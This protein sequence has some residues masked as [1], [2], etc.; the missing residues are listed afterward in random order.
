MFSRLR[1]HFGTAGL[2]VAI[3]ALI[4]ALAGG[5]I[6]ATGGDGG[7]K[8][9]A[10][11][12]KGPRGP[13]GAKGDTGPAGPQGPAGANGKDGLD[14]LEGEEGEKGEK[15]AKGGKGSA[16]S[17]GATGPTGATGATGAAGATGPT[18]P[19][20]ATGP[21]GPEGVCSTSSCV[22]PPGVALRGAW[23][24]G[25]FQALAASEP[26]FLPISFT[27]PLSAN[28]STYYVKEGETENGGIITPKVCKGGAA[29]PTAENTTGVAL[30]VFATKEVNWALPTNSVSGV[31]EAGNSK[32]SAKKQGVV[33]EGKTGA[34][35]PA[36]AYGTW[37][38]RRAP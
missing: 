5:A 10:S 7:G 22:L 1:E 21:T 35:G 37:V 25:Q 16:G 18:G 2:A 4:A 14:G 11:A 29:N 6:A 38:L 20:G 15:G 9:T 17:E 27:V 34:A 13:K 31:V 32:I 36:Y 23:A 12:E 19:A 24:V 26:L 30:C 8:A 3:V 28:P 33:F